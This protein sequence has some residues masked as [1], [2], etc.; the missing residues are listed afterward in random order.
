MVRAETLAA[1]PHR[2]NAK[3]SKKIDLAHRLERGR[4]GRR[5]VSSVRHP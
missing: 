2:H 1:N 4:R 5:A 3:S